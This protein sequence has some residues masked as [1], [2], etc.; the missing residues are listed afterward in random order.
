[1]RPSVAG[2]VDSVHVTITRSIARVIWCGGMIRWERLASR[3][4]RR[5]R[6]PTQQP[7]RIAAKQTRSQSVQILTEAGSGARRIAAITATVLLGT[8]MVYSATLKVLPGCEN[9]DTYR[10]PVLYVV[11]ARNAR[12]AARV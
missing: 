9:L 2:G 5:P 10:S 8:A 7:Q 12:I 4:A 1:M 6:A 11:V 3:T